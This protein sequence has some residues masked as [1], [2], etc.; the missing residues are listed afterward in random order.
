MKVLVACE[1]SGIVRDAFAELGHHAVSCDLI[2]TEKPGFH[3]QCDVRHLLKADWDLLIAHPPCTYLSVS[4][5][6][7][8]KNNPERKKQREQA[9][10]FFMQFV[11]A[12]ISMKC[13]ENPVGIMSTVYRKPD[14]Y[15][16]PY[17]FG[18]PETKKTGLWLYGLPKL[19]PT[20]LVTPEYII[21]KDGNKYSRIHYLSQWKHPT[22]RAKERSRTYLGVA[23]A[24]AEQW[25]GI[26]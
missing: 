11:D 15:I 3:F 21:G 24:M 17:H 5:N 23:K 13:I 26:A 18:H 8:M 22:D 12:E 4:G 7:W 1:F 16:E 14:Q 9:I 10:N 20:E 2:Q 6:R 25:G 19:Q